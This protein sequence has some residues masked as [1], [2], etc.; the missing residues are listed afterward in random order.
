[1]NDPISLLINESICFTISEL[2]GGPAAQRTRMLGWEG[3][4]FGGRGWVGEF[5]FTLYTMLLQ[6]WH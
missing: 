6:R 4:W 1:M 5:F 2:S 3:Q